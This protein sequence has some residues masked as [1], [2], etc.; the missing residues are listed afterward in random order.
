MSKSIDELLVKI[1]NINSKNKPKFD[2][3]NWF[4]D[5]LNSKGKQLEMPSHLD[6]LIDKRK[7]ILPL[8]NRTIKRPKYSNI[9]E[10]NIYPQY[11]R[12][13]AYPYPFTASEQ[14]K[15]KESGK[16]LVGK[17]TNIVDGLKKWDDIENYAL[18]T[19]TRKRNKKIRAN[20]P[21]ALSNKEI[22][23]VESSIKK[24]NGNN[25]ATAGFIGALSDM[26]LS[27]SLNPKNILKRSALSSVHKSFLT[28]MLAKKYYDDYNDDPMA[29]AQALKKGRIHSFKTKDIF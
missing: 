28:R 26:F 21:L 9:P 2:V 24:D 20:D 25:E 23:E 11:E 15:R 6:K 8:S 29:K 19:Q 7:Y 10:L 22:A 12:E 16:S 1:N 18:D 27:Q 17:L 14:S 4:K 3:S 13:E 5:T